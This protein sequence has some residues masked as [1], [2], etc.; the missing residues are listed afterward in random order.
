[1]DDV[2]GGL[3]MMCTGQRAASP[4]PAGPAPFQATARGARLGSGVCEET[5]I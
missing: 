3:S 5:P 1:M 4:G 2:K